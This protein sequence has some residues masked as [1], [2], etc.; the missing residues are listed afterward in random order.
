MTT[1]RPVDAGAPCPGSE[2]RL[3]RGLS[4]ALFSLLNQ[5]SRVASSPSNIWTG[6]LGMI[7]DM[8]CL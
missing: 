5:A 3:L 1:A 4:P 6:W 8:A 2:L 7:V